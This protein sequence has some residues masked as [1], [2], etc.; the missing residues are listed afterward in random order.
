[1]LLGLA[2]VA[3]IGSC[4]LY[5]M[6][7]SDVRAQCFDRGGVSFARAINEFRRDTGRI[8]TSYEEVEQWLT[9]HPDHKPDPD[10]YCKLEEVRL[11]SDEAGFELTFRSRWLMMAPS[12]SKFQWDKD[13]L[14]VLP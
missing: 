4:A 9:S 12:S 11:T 14:R 8:P 13:S 6:I 7:V 10:P 3:M 2:A 5:L 1:M